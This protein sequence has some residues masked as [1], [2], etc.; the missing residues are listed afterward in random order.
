[1]RAWLIYD[2][3]E[4]QRNAAY[5]AV[6]FA[7][8]RERHI[9]LRL[10]L[11]EQIQTGIVANR[12]VIYYNHIP[13]AAPD[14]VICRTINPRLTYQFEQLGI[15]VFNN[16]QVSSICNDKGRTYQYVSRAQVPIMDTL[17]FRRDP[18]SSEPPPVPAQDSFG[19]PLV[20]KPASGKGGRQVFLV[21][22]PGEL[23]QA[24]AAQPAGDVI[25]QKV[26]SD[27]GRD[28]RV[29]VIGRRIVAAMLRTSPTDFRSNYCLGGRAEIYPLSNP[30]KAIIHRIIDL[31][32]F[33]LAGI[34][35]VF[36]G[37][38]LILNEIEDVVGS[39][40]LYAKTDINIAAEYLDAI[41]ARI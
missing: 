35:F 37:G 40:M 29:Y 21:H 18:D 23:S 36:H 32:D 12:A 16:F 38:Q 17:I 11:A 1:M 3:F 15:P 33:G 19:F 24:W 8:C 22:N 30:E 39:R 25:I 20:V 13:Q 34:D 10:L 27:I 4:A 5:I 6:Y 2:A 31:F 7:A 9:E 14:F 41:A 26:A 28:L